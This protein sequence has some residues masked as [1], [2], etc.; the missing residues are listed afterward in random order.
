MDGDDRLLV[1]RRTIPCQNPNSRWLSFAVSTPC[2]QQNPFT[3]TRVFLPE[4]HEDLKLSIRGLLRLSILTVNR[5]PDD[6][7]V[8]DA[9]VIAALAALVDV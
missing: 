6:W 8:K 9:E 3:C 5:V 4:G 2:L 7:T 1:T